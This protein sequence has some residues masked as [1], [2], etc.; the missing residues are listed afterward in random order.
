MKTHF[1]Y[2]IPDTEELHAFG[3]WAFGEDFMDASVFNSGID[4]M[5]EWNKRHSAQLLLYPNGLIPEDAPKMVK[6]WKDDR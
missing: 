6:V 3:L 1:Q 4:F 2:Y 5:A